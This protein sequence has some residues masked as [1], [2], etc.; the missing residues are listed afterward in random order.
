MNL[1]CLQFVGETS[2][3]CFLEWKWKGVFCIQKKIQ[4]YV[5]CACWFVAQNNTWGKLINTEDSNSSLVD[6]FT[7]CNS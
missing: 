6:E 2:R 5:A 7:E 3:L 4:E 1:F